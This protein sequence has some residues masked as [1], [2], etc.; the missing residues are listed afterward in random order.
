VAMKERQEV[1]WAFDNPVS[2]WNAASDFNLGADSSIRPN[3]FV[4]AV[5]VPGEV[6]ATGND[7]LLHLSPLPDGYAYMNVTGVVGKIRASR[8]LAFADPDARVN[9]ILQSEANHWIPMGSLSLSEM[10]ENWTN[11]EFRIT[12][13]ELL[14]A[15]NQ[16][17]A[18]RFQLQSKNAVRGRLYLDD[19]G[20]IFRT[21][22]KSPD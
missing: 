10:S 3:E 19:L 4:A 16:L 18:I 2:E 1:V 13:S 9:V 6:P 5:E 14:E 12:D 7:N 17:Y 8:D 22:D 11:L 15:M 20:L 21:S